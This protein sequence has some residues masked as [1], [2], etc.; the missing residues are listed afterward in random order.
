[1]MNSRTSLGI[2]A[3]VLVSAA[4]LT[5]CGPKGIYTP[6]IAVQLPEKYNTPDGMVLTESG[7]ILLC[8][9]NFGDD[10]HPAAIVRIDKDDKISEVCKLPTHP[11]T[12][13]VGPLGIDIGPDGNL[14]VADNQAFSTNEHKSRLLR[15]VMKNGKAVR[16]EAVVTGFVMSNAVA[17]HGD[18][19]Y[20]TETK[21]DPDAYP[22]PSGVYRFKLSEL[23]AARPIKLLPG[24]KDKHLIAKIKT[25][26]KDYP[27]GANGMGFDSKG[28]MFVCNFGDAEL[29]KFTFDKK[30][31]VKSQEVFAKGDGMKST[32]GLK[33]HP[34]TDDI[35]IADFVANAVHRVCAK[36][37]KVTVLAINDNTDGAGGKLDKCSEV[38]IRGCKVYVA[39]IDLTLWGNTYDDLHTISVINLKKCC[40]TC[41]KA[42]SGDC[43]KK[44]CCGTCQKKKACCGK[45]KK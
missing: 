23:N 33:I 5:G 38:C 22:L 13:K 42:C 12:G 39:N 31:N 4:V 32:D 1:M 17:C 10:S 25:M 8:V 20:V 14:Y 41:K 43:G 7:D 2:L 18:S 11:E 19:V 6:T 34:K 44:A 24:G 40:G 45:C 29:L 35:Y 27:V 37:G 16:T 36:T 28:N 15:V 9:P 26:S 3:V 30:G 21:I